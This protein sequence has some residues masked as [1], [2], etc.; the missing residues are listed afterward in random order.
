M[1]ACERRGGGQQHGAAETTP[2]PKQSLMLVAVIGNVAEVTRR[3]PLMAGLALLVVAVLAVAGYCARKSTQDGAPPPASAS[4]PVS[5]LATVAA[6]E[7]PKEAI[8]TLTLI[9]KGG[10]F[11][12][13]K[14]GSTFAN[15]ERLLPLR[16][17][18]YYR[19]YTVQTPGSRDRGARRLVVGQAGDVYCTADHYE[20]FRQVLR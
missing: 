8:V 10:P 4:T 13:E 6:A 20:S 2:P 5:G 14:D 12:Y 18:G 11:P 15:Q 1:G 9:D 19:E 17:R 3:Y 16:E 7:L